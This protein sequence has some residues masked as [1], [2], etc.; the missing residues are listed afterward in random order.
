MSVAA[1]LAAL[2]LTFVSCKKDE[3]DTVNPLISIPKNPVSSDAGIQFIQISAGKD[4]GLTMSFDGEQ[5]PWASLS[6]M[7]GKGSVTNLTLDWDENTVETS[8]SVS[9]SIKSAAGTYAVSFTQYGKGQSPELPAPGQGA[10][11]SACGWLELPATKEGDGREFFHHNMQVDG[12]TIR[13]FSYDYSYKDFISLW[14]AY[15]LNKALIGSYYGRSNAWG[16]DPL[17]P[18]NAQQSIYRSYGTGHA[19]GHQIPSADRQ[20]GYE[21]NAPTFYATNLT[22]QDFDFNGGIWAGLEMDVRDICYKSDTLY[23]VTGCVLGNE[24][25]YNGGHSVNVPAAYFK[26]LLYYSTG[27]TLGAYSGYSGAGIYM[28]HDGELSGDRYDFAM[29]LDELQKKTGLEFFVNLPENIRS[30]VLV[31]NPSWAEPYL[32]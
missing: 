14:V 3:P 21:R 7:S 4:W 24:T 23:V 17:L 11:V 20:G 10:D 31:Q 1:L 13:N 32:N 6:A 16:F 15:P 5:T 2:S 8:R 22:P 26:A 18:S 30:K 28:R 27:G 9:I 19:R 25:I 12:K 29:T